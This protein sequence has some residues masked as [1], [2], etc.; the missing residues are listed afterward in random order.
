MC[1]GRNRLQQRA[2]MAAPARPTAPAPARVSFV[3]QGNGALTVRGPVTGIEYR[4]DRPGARVEVDAR[5]RILLASLRQL[6][7]VL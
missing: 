3:N 6:R 2:A 7:Q 1:C 5:D 4:F